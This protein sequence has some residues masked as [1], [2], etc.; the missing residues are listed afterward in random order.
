[1]LSVSKTQR[2]PKSLVSAMGAPCPLCFP[3]WELPVL[4]CGV[5]PVTPG[6]RHHTLIVSFPLGHP[7]R[8]PQLQEVRVGSAVHH[9]LSDVPGGTYQLI[10]PH[11][12][13]LDG[14]YVIPN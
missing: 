6:W 14:Y 2:S 4:C 9:I 10:R 13:L 12:I 7:D 11:A 1:M 3:M 8:P 5:A